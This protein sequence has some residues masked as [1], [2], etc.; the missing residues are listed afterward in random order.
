MC[1]SMMIKQPL[2]RLLVDVTVFW[3]LLIVL[4]PEK[5]VFS[6]TRWLMLYIPPLQICISVVERERNCLR[7]EETGRPLSSHTRGGSISF[8]SPGI[9][10]RNSDLHC[11]WGDI[12]QRTEA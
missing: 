5:P 6:Y 9:W 2:E 11:C 12:W 1:W 8:T 3:A 4:F 10:K 7:G